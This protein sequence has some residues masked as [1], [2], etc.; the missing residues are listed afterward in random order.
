MYSLPTL[1]LLAIIAFILAKG[2]IRIIVKEDGSRKRVD[3]LQ[4]EIALNT[5]RI[6]ELKGR[7]NRLGTPEGIEDEIKDKFSVVPPGEYV[8][9]IV[10]DKR[11]ATTTDGSEIPWYK[12]IWSAII[13]TQ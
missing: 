6:E 13:G 9:I 2:A 1:I 8:A 12:K 11:P 5:A 7:I 3:S 4:A 10:D